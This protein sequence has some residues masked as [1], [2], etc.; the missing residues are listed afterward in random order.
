VSARFDPLRDHRVDTSRSGRLRLGDRTDLHEHLDP[1]AVR[2]I[3]ERRR[4]PPEEDE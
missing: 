4:W 2:T 3:H 1:V